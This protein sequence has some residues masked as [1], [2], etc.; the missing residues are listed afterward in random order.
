MKQRRPRKPPTPIDA[1]TLERLA[2]AYVGRY[3]T[4]RAKLK[5]YLARKLKQRG[6]E[7]SGAPPLEDISEKCARL[8]FVDDAAFA[9]GRAA[10]FQR[11]GYGER[12]LTEALKAAGVSEAD[13]ALARE[14]ARNAAAAAVLRF[15]ERKR[16]GPFAA[17]VPSRE[18]K[19]RQF[20]MMARAGHPSDLIRRLLDAVP[21][22]I[23]EL[24]ST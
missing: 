20:A 5:A 18:Q 7:E 21:G 22:D 14:E 15:A 10:A 6:W 1:E 17:D 12:R 3:A 24:D 9:A 8:G 11:R 13:A 23:P 19:R 16:L 2:L 4:T